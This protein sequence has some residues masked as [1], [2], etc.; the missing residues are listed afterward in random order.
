MIHQLLLFYLDNL[1]EVFVEKLSKKYIQ[2]NWLMYEREVEHK[3]TK[4]QKIDN[5]EII[6][7]LGV[8]LVIC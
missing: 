2:A 3:K 1:N 8:S 5:H 6:T 7:V 4:K